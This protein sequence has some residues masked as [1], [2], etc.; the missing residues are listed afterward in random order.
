MAGPVH[1]GSRANVKYD[2]A[3]PGATAA[4][5]QEW[6]AAEAVDRREAR[7][8]AN[9]RTRRA[10]GWMVPPAV[11]AAAASTV[12][13]WTP[14]F[15]ATD[16]EAAIIASAVAALLAVWI[17]PLANRLAKP[18]AG[19]AADDQLL[20]TAALA[21]AAAAAVHFAVIGMHFAE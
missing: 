12:L 8:A 4:R 11:L 18:L 6:L 21:S 9:A 3:H 16:T 1:S 13:W 7:E 20:F 15:S 10:V 17:I 2:A 14:G 19:S 5:E